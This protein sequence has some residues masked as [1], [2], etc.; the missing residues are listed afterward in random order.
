MTPDPTNAPLDESVDLASVAPSQES[1]AAGLTP[2][3]VLGVIRRRWILIATAFAVVTAIGAWRTVRQPRIYEATA[4]VRFQQPTPAV[5]GMSQPQV[6]SF[7]IDPLQSEQLLIRSESVAERAATLSG[8]R[9]QIVRPS[10][11]R[12]VVFGDSVPLVEDS[13][14]A[15]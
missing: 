1:G 2:R 4:T 14:K 15:G 7:T 8:L 13:A 9:V 10:Q 11:S 6:R 12:R 5:Q 3:E